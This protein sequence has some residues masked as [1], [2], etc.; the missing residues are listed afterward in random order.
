[1]LIAAAVLA[2]GGA[3]YLCNNGMKPAEHRIFHGEPADL[4]SP[5]GV[6]RDALHLQSQGVIQLGIL[7]L[8]ATPVARVVFTV[9]AFA[10]QKDV[11]YVVITLF[12]LCVLL[13]SIFSGY[14]G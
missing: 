7:L 10:K 4:D 13:Y 5:L 3:M 12:V 9:F 6:I 11:T 2:I 1:V 8:I 14:M